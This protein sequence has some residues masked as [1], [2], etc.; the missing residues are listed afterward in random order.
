MAS[1]SSGA[2]L[3]IERLYPGDQGM[4]IMPSTGQGDATF[5]YENSRW[6]RDKTLARIYYEELEELDNPVLV[7]EALGL[8]P[9]DPTHDISIGPRL[10]VPR[11]FAR[12]WLAHRDERIKEQRERQSLTSKVF[13]A[14]AGYVLVACV[15][16]LVAA[17]LSILLPD[18]LYRL[19]WL[20]ETIR[21]AFLVATAITLLAG[22]WMSRAWKKEEQKKWR[23]RAAWMR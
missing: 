18:S 12:D 10:V 14:C 17:P 1:G 19:P 22:W 6:V 23:R 16:V 13:A 15:L 9:A 5:D 3:A 20:K 11:G 7:R 4:G 2:I 21:T 8:L